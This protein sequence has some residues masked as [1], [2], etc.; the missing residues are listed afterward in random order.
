MNLQPRH[1][2]PL[3]L[4]LAAL[5]S[6]ALLLA[7]GTNSPTGLTG[8][9]EYFLGLRIP[10]EMMERND[11]WIPFI[12][13]EPRLRKPPFIYWLTR[14][15]YES[16]GANL[17]SA[18][19]VTVFFSLLL[20]TST[21]WLG[22]HLNG[23][24]TDGLLAAGIMLGFA[25]MATESRRLM[26]DIPI[27]ALSTTAFCT[28]LTW[29]KRPRQ[30]Y[31]V[32]TACLLTAALMSKGPIALVGFASGLAAFWLSEAQSM[33]ARTQ[34]AG[35]LYLRE[36]L[37][38]HAG[39]YL[40]CGIL[41][42]LLPALWYF[43][44]V[45][46]YP[47]QFAAAA[48]DEIEA[49]S[50]VGPSAAPLFG[51]LLLTLPWAPV[52]IN[53]LLRARHSAEIRFLGYWLAMSLLP[54]FFLRSFERYLL[55]SLPAFALIC[56]YGLQNGLHTRWPVRLGA[57]LPILAAGTLSALLW[58]WEH[59]ASA[60]IVAGTLLVFTL[61]WNI[62]SGGRALITS[63]ALLWSVVW[64]IGFPQLG[65][66][67]IPATAIELVKNRQVLMFEGPQPALLPILTKRTMRHVQSLNK[68]DILLNPGTIISFQQEDEPRVRDELRKIQRSARE[69]YRYQSLTSAGSGIRFAKA[70]STWQDWALAWR[71]RNPRHLMSTI[72]FYEVLP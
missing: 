8:K 66:N 64:G 31:L 4:A 17:T 27:A 58:R 61:A 54:F 6:A 51:I 21:A 16:F 55:G 71:E 1:A 26:L 18:R 49:R 19:L 13:S 47:E 40:A 45:R 5:F 15:T 52:G 63:A 39:A 50:S 23:K 30:S 35:V 72:I 53:T 33:N 67:S 60:T 12:D 69:I 22:K 11:W 25:G 68:E 37:K 2:R 48:R 46:T 7:L 44:V 42:G 41:A 59:P 62:P 20:M 56:A 57:L 43:D 24:W 3:I 36:H 14:L 9:D 28:Y 32:L 34:G 38:Q 65:V 29:L 10:L 70:G